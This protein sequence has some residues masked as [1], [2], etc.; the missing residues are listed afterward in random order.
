[1]DVN[2]INEEENKLFNR[3]EIRFEVNH[4]GSDTPKLID[5]RRALAQKT[6]TDTSHVVIDGFKTLF[7][8][9]RT[10]G[11][12]R[13]YKDMDELKD[14]E[15]N[16]LLKRNKIIEDEALEAGKEEA[17]ENKEAKKEEKPKEEKKEENP[18]EKKEDDKKE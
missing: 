3:K 11:D 13:I 4:E 15:P 16:Y 7:G 1:M 14:Y 10:I 17:E 9:G 12:A 8:I 18:A 6:G 5:V 2:I